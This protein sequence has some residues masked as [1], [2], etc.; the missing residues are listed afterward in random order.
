M[1]YSH[2][3]SHAEGELQRKQIISVDCRFPWLF[4]FHALPDSV[5]VVS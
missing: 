4:F 5:R 2:S 1:K 3:Y